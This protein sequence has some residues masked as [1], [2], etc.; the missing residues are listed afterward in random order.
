MVDPVRDRV[1]DFDGEGP[2]DRGD[3]SNEVDQSKRECR[4]KLTPGAR[5]RVRL[6]DRTIKRSKD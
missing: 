1:S 6:R 2:S 5:K 4:R 3:M